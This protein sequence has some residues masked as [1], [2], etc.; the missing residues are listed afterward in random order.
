MGG[1]LSLPARA[2]G[3]MPAA[4]SLRTASST[5][6]QVVGVSVMP[7]RVKSSLLYQNPTMPMSNG[8]P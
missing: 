1:H 4:L 6:V 2:T 8:M 3:V 5:P 7:A